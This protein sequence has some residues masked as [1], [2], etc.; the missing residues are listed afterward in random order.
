[1]SWT[2]ADMAAMAA[3]D[4]A[5]FR[6]IVMEGYEQ[7]ADAYL[8]EHAAKDPDD[9]RMEAWLAVS[10]GLSEGAQVVDAGCGAGV[11]LAKAIVEDPRQLHVIG[12]DCSPRQI[13]LARDFIQ[14]P[15]ARFICGDMSDVTDQS[16]YTRGSVVE[17]GSIDVVCAFFSVFHIPRTDHEKFFES[18]YG[19]LKPGGYFVFNLGDGD[20]DGEG[21]ASYEPD[22]LG[23]GMLW[24]SYSRDKTVELLTAVGFEL[25]REELKTVTHSDGV[26][27]AGLQFRFYTTRRPLPTAAAAAAESEPQPGPEPAPTS[28]T[29]VAAAEAAAAA[30]AAAV[31]ATTAAATTSSATLR[32]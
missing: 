1:M 23:A 18:V 17:L 4:G 22:F 9:L 30:A 15:R 24:S 7:C 32:R 11:P 8:A 12:I 25:I 19:W 20:G 2:M 31:A 28:T 13:G 21:E 16:G 27:E 3:A 10:S 6:L 29:P 5:V 14:S 26:D